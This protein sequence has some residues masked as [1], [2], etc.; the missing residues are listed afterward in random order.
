MTVTVKFC[1]TTDRYKILK[2]HS[3]LQTE[4]EYYNGNQ[5]TNRYNVHHNT[6]RCELLIHKHVT[7]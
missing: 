7:S 5:I 3:T 2:L 4:V 1:Y 6:T